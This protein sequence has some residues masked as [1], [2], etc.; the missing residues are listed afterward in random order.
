MY[1]VGADAVGE[2]FREALAEP[3]PRGR[4]GVRHLRRHR[5]HRHDAGLVAAALRGRGARRRVSTPSRRSTRASASTRVELRDHRKL[6]VVDG[7]RGLHGRHQPGAP[8]GS[9]TSDGGAGWR[10]DMIEV[11]GEAH[12]GDADALLPHVAQAHAA[13]AAR[14]T[15]GPCRRKRRG[16]SGCSPASGACGAA[17][18]ASTSCASTARS[19]ASTSPTRTSCPTAASARRSSAPCAAA[20]TCASSCP[21]RATCPSCS[22]PSR[23]SSTRSCEHGVEICVAA[24]DDAA[25]ED[26]HHRRGVHDHRQ[27]QPRR[28]LVAQEPRGEPRRGGRSDFARHVRSWFER[29]LEPAARVELDRVA[30]PLATRGAALEWAAF[31]MRKLW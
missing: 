16:P 26:G 9:P 21:R 11:R 23:R 2:R 3:G 22:S 29:D 24:R 7:A 31:A 6:L 30:R 20:C 10:D 17:S 27:L 8:R 5:Q 1:W 4:E 12:A 28:A 13:R 15:C 25:R 18:T 14:R 19:R